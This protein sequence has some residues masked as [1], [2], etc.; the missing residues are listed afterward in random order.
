METCKQKPIKNKAIK[1][2][3]IR[4]AEAKLSR[5][6]V[7]FQALF[8]SSDR[9]RFADID[10]QRVLKAGCRGRKTHVVIMFLSARYNDKRVYECQEIYIKGTYRDHRVTGALNFH[11]IRDFCILVMVLDV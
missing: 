9:C 4:E 1:V 11:K 8:E 10:C 2:L 7:R 3:S 6:K 5:K